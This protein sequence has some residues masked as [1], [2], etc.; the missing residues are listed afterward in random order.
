LP[1]IKAYASV[2]NPAGVKHDFIFSFHFVIPSHKRTHKPAIQPGSS[3]TSSFPPT[4]LL[5]HISV[6]I[7]LQ[8][9]RFQAPLHRFLLLCHL[10]PL[11][12][13]VFPL[14]VRTIP[15]IC[16]PLSLPFA[17][18]YPY[19]LHS[20]TPTRLHPFRRPPFSISLILSP[21]YRD[22]MSHALSLPSSQ[23]YQYLSTPISNRIV[24]PLLIL[25]RM[26]YPYSDR[27][28]TSLQY[29]YQ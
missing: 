17:L 9:S 2:C 4:L 27:V 16:T 10:P 1:T 5:H 28:G 22:L 12:A 8:S 15:T 23:S 25:I 3:T 18:H 26:Y 20:I 13:I 29:S 24:T 11:I 7:S 21:F 14:L 6:R 19:H